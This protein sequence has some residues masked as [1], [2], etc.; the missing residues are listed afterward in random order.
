M[1][2]LFKYLSISTAI[3][4]LAYAVI[5]YKH[6][7]KFKEKV[8]TVVDKAADFAADHPILTTAVFATVVMVPIMAIRKAMDPAYNWPDEDD[9][10]DIF[11][12]WKED[13][14][15]NWDRVNEFA[16]TLDL[17]EGESFMIEE[18][19]QYDCDGTIV[20]HLIN[21]EGCYPPEM[22]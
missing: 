4:T 6:D 7:E 2:K 14:R 18:G 19:S 15:N 11:N 16:K 5:K 17:V 20:S 3:G 12:N 13:Y 22:D 1:S 8:D 9:D 21:S 10:T